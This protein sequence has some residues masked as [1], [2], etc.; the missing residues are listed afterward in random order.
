MSKK[1]GEKSEAFVRI[2][3]LLISGVVLKIWSFLAFAL[4]FINWIIALIQGYRNK[5]IAEFCEYWNTSLYEYF[6]YLS[7]LTNKR[8]FPFGAYLRQMG[9]FEN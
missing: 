9:K 8:P 2:A 4:M 7:G 3:V 5:Q 1:K 6:R